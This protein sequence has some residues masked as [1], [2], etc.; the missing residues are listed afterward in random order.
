MEWEVD[1]LAEVDD[2]MEHGVAVGEGVVDGHA[3]AA[4]GDVEVGDTLPAESASGRGSSSKPASFANAQ[5]DNYKD[6]WP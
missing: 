6:W 4:C 5:P 2:G 1:G 3:G